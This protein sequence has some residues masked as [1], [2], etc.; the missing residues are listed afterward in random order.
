MSIKFYKGD[1]AKFNETDHGGGI[2]FTNDTKEILTGAEQS[3]GKNADKSV[4]T[5]EI[6][7]VGGP[8]AS[9]AVK[10]AFDGG[11]IPANTSV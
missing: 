9:D 8:L 5:E 4:T 1:S 10:N 3:Y 7:I 6:T 11:V 2:Y